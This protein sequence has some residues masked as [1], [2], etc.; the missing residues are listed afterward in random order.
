MDTL[1]RFKL[2]VDKSKEELKLESLEV[3]RSSSDDRTI[4]YPAGRKIPK[5]I[6]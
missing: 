5:N 1:V 6:G 2:G 3:V 4:F